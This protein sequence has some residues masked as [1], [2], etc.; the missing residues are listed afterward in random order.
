MLDKDIFQTLARCSDALRTE[1]DNNCPVM[2]K[3]THSYMVELA[4]E[5][6]QHCK[7]AGLFAKPE[8]SD[9]PWRE[10]GYIVRDKHGHVVAAMP[11][12]S[13]THSLEEIRANAARIVACVNACA[14]VASDDLGDVFRILE[15][16][17]DAL[18]NNPP[19]KPDD[20][21][22]TSIDKDLET[23]RR[24]LDGVD[25]CSK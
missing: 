5:A 10:A 7:D 3:P 12:S 4:D 19:S 8:H 14:G 16:L 13:S 11:T 9:T 17:L 15:S 21:G 23:A 18:T 6:R 22:R 1:A 2:N 24:I 20:Y 25:K